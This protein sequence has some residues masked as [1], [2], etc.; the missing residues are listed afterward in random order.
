MLWYIPIRQQAVPASLWKHASCLIAL[1]LIA[2]C[3][4]QDQTLAPDWIVDQ[5]DVLHAEDENALTS[6]LSDFYDSTSVALAG[7][8][9]HSLHGQP[10]GQYAESLYNLWELGD[11]EMQN[12]MLILLLT[13][14][15]VVHITMGSGIAQEASPQDLDSVKTRMADYFVAGDYRSGFETGFDFLMRRAS[16]L[17]WTVAYRS[18][19]DAERDSSGSLHQILSAEGVVTGFEEDLVVLTDSD[20]REVR[21]TAPADAPVLS[22]D[23][24]IGFT[25]RIVDTRPLHV[26]VLNLEVDFAF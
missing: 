24:V 3:L 4:P 10:V 25:G 19:A 20:G 12:G 11:L 7:V 18:I 16:A 22:A 23:D 17:S 21:L 13:D 1:V 14:D 26:R 6:L 2:G 5:A 15:R 9:L 8:T